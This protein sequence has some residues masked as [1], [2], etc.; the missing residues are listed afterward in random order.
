MILTRTNMCRYPALGIR[1]IIPCT[2][3]S[4]QKSQFCVSQGAG[5]QRREKIGSNTNRGN[6]LF[7][8]SKHLQDCPSLKRCKPQRGD[9][10]VPVSWGWHPDSTPTPVCSAQL[11][12]ER[13][14]KHRDCFCHNSWQ[15]QQKE[16]RKIWRTKCILPSP[17]G[18]IKRQI[19]A[20]T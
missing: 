13:G 18:K 5:E 19:F 3:T 2:S 16:L 20:S 12:V 1:I 8:S 10:P 7:S 15:S 9:T 6:D 14:L 4:H 17:H 11:S